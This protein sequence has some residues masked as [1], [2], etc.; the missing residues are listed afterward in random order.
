M[1]VACSKNAFPIGG[2]VTGLSGTPVVLQNNGGDDLTVNADGTFTFQTLGAS[3]ATHAV[4][5]KTSRYK[6][7]PKLCT[8]DA[9]YRHRFE[10]SGHQRDDQLR[11]PHDVQ[12]DQRR[13]LCGC[14]W[15]LRSI[16]MGPERCLL[17]RRS[18]T[19]PQTVAATINHAVK[20]NRH[21]HDALRPAEFVHGGRSEDGGGAVQSYMGR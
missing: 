3:G 5:V 15:R 19:R 18:A 13:G 17:S 10:R 11:H 14:G 2:T 1:S 9:R 4:T 16:P 6:A 12:S 20:G 21:Q 7:R 8:A